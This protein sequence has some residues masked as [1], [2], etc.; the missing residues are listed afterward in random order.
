MP[1]RP[2][3]APRSAARHI[4]PLLCAMM[5]AAACQPLDE[6][7]GADDFGV[8]AHGGPFRARNGWAVTFVPSGGSTP[9]HC[10]GRR[11]P[12]PNGLD[13]T[14]IGGET[15]SGFVL[16]GLPPERGV[17]AKEEIVALFDDGERRTYAARREGDRGLRVVFPT[18]HYDETLHPFARGEHV[19][20][21][22]RQIGALG[23]LD[24]NGSSWAINATDE[25]RRIN[26]PPG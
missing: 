15:R 3:P 10:R 17:P 13:L 11:D 25:C 18:R 19:V 26:V 6:P 20:M 12:V 14:I 7:P 4:L 2:K 9:A 23:T 8:N 1:D 21:R 16:R 24:L 22:G 5:L